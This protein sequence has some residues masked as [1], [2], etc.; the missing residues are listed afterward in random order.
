M[1]KRSILEHPKVAAW[2]AAMPPADAREV[3][4][5]CA[6]GRP[7]LPQGH[8]PFFYYALACLDTPP[9]PDP[10]YSPTAGGW[11]WLVALSECY[12]KAQSDVVLQLALDHAGTAQDLKHLS[13]TPGLDVP[14]S[15]LSLSDLH[16]LAD[17]PGS[18]LP[19]LT[20]ELCMMQADRE[21]T[22]APDHIALKQSL[23]A[24]RL[25]LDRAY[26]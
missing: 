9:S 18:T 3:E 14:W 12:E 11:S 7:A 19:S 24:K 16:A 4:G 5:L 23:A 10:T 13:E 17:Q 2:L 26:C 6:L 25:E 8:R 20:H 22:L 21:R 1:S 15:L